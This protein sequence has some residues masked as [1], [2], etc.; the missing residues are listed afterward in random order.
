MTGTK[1]VVGSGIV[2]A[3]AGVADVVTPAFGAI[4]DQAPWAVA[5]IVI[6]V[7]FLWYLRDKE[8]HDR[9]ERAQLIDILGSTKDIMGST[10]A[11]MERANR[12]L[13]DYH[14]EVRKARTTGQVDVK[15]LAAELLRAR[16]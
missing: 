10:K 5:F 4:G 6:V 9:E 1:A 15:E 2:L 7:L 11:V 14:S 12:Q 13:D 16:E 8:Q 3:V